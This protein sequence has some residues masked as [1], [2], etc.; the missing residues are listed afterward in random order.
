MT[1]STGPSRF[2]RLSIVIVMA[3][4]YL[5]I[6]ILIIFS[7]NKSKLVTVWGGFSTQWYAS[8]LSNAALL[9]GARVSF[10]VA[11]VSATIATLL[12]LLAALV[13]VRIRRFRGRQL[14]TGLLAAPMVM[15]EVVLG[16]SMLLMFVALGINRGPLTIILAHATFTMCFAA[17]VLQ[18]RLT[19]LDPSLE[20][21]ARDLGCPPATAFL[22][23]ALPN[24][25]PAL[26]SAWLL[27]FTLSLDDL[28]ISSFTTG[29]GAST[30]PMKIYSQ[31]KFGVTPE[32]NAVSTIILGIVALG[33]LIVALTTRR[34]GEGLH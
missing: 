15:P 34:A 7:F 12:G 18:S 32:I 24:I 33:L 5:P 3:F 28:V 4:L 27:S 30:L 21:A 1:V 22:K 14:F 29:P 20:E 2:N 16:V 17:V 6:M 8:A 19:E 10:T 26:T 25:L 23:V 31:I 13:I 11:A 9:D